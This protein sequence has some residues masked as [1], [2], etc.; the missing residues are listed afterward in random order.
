MHKPLYLL[1]R[2]RN[3]HL[4]FDSAGRLLSKSD[5]GPFTVSGVDVQS[6]DLGSKGLTI[7]GA[8][9]GLVFRGD[10]I[11][12]LGLERSIVVQIAPSPNGEYGSSL[13][14]IFTSN[15]A[16]FIPSLPDYWQSYGTKHLLHPIVDVAASEDKDGPP[17]PGEEPAPTIPAPGTRKIGGAVSPP[18]V[19]HA[20]APQFDREARAVKISGNVLVY[21]QVD[22]AGLP[23]NIRLLRPL[24][25]GLDEKAVEAVSQYKFQPAMLNGSP[26]RVEMNVEVNFQIY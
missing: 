1:G 8:R 2:W 13:D 20:P 16:A 7:H 22:T 18:R 10:E 9:V 5:V 24:G 23:T 26:V 15:L 21:L 25:F 3:D 17:L 4:K 19:L 11:Q 6:I 12:R 14:A